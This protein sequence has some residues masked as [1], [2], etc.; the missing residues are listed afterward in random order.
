[1]DLTP[2]DVEDLLEE[3]HAYHALYSAL[4]Q[5]REQREQAAKYLQGLLLEL[6]SKS[7]EP[8]VLALEGAKSQAVRAMQQFISEGRWDDTALLTTLGS[9]GTARAPRYPP[10]RARD[11]NPR[12]PVCWQG[13]PS[14]KRWPSWLPCCPP[15]A[16]C[17]GRSR[18]GVKGLWWPALPGCG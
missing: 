17:G 18:K 15:T 9:G 2:R 11:A 7:I 10:A 14:R 4:F 6:P 13:Q 12:A 8:L 5:R 1:M 16:G 3:L